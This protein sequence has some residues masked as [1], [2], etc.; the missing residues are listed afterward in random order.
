MN[1]KILKNQKG[2]T[3]LELMIGNL[4]FKGLTQ[5]RVQSSTRDITDGLVQQL[6]DSNQVIE[7]IV[8]DYG[9]NQKDNNDRYVQAVCIGN[10]RYT[11][12]TNTEIGD[13]GAYGASSGTFKHIMW[14]D[15]TS[16]N[17]AN[18]GSFFGS[19]PPV[20]LLVPDPSTNIFDSGTDLV[21]PNTLL[22]P[23]YNGSSTNAPPPVLS[24]SSPYTINVNL[25]YG[26]YDLLNFTGPTVSCNGGVGDK[27]CATSSLTVTVV[28]RLE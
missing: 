10:V 24:S 5:S 3:I 8:E 15:S 12:V 16:A 6:Q 1:H 22:N 23:L 18:N 28:Q 27:F 25:D 20:N 13:N 7:S 2:F 21:G 26:A 9:H 19:C 11:F 17:F 14:R 4:Y